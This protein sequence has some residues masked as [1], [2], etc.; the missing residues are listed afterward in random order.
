MKKML[1]E[2]APRL[3]L[4]LLFLS[5]AIDGLWFV[6]TGA[7]LLM[8][9]P[10]SARGAQFE[11]ALF[12]AGFLWPF[13]KLVELIAALCLLTNRAPAFGLALLAPI[14][15]VIV[16]FHIFLNPQGLP[17]AAVLIVLGGLLVRVYAKRYASLFAMGAGE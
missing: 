14:M 7:H 11:A 17:V 10:V 13:M 16:L 9:P 12:A 1:F 5:G 4:G 2:T 15:S 6:V 3:I 8:D